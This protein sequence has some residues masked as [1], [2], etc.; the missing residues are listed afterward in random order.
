MGKYSSPPSL[1]VLLK[2]SMCPTLR[3]YHSSSVGSNEGKHVKRGRE[4]LG[5]SSVYSCVH[6]GRCIAFVVE[7]KF[8]H[9]QERGLHREWHRSFVAS[10]SLASG[11]SRLFT[12]RFG[13]MPD[14]Y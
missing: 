11:S 9:A 14:T 3:S 10:I 5:A 2:N 1:R 7:R 13:Q 6:G 12:H 4:P 8:S